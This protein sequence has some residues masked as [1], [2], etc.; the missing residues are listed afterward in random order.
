MAS[1]TLPDFS[2]SLILTVVAFLEE[3]VG[4]VLH[5]AW[6]R[7]LNKA[8]CIP[9]APQTSR[10]RE[11][12][13]TVLVSLHLFLYILVRFTLVVPLAF[14]SLSV[15]CRN[16]TLSV[17]VPCEELLMLSKVATMRSCTDVNPYIYIILGLAQFVLHANTPWFTSL[18][19]IHFLLLLRSTNSSYHW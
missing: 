7:L 11:V 6:T 10:T 5:L 19:K 3:H 9:L 4:E 12:V 8:G 2:S 13:H 17:L 14:H 15:C 1:Y 16:Q 18:A